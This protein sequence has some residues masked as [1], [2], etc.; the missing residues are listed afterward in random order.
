M[1]RSA[2]LPSPS[3][4][5][6]S[7]TIKMPQSTVQ[8]DRILRFAPTVQIYEVFSLKNNPD[9]W[10]KAKDYRDILEESIIPVVVHLRAMEEENDTP[11]DTDLSEE[12]YCTRGLEAM[13]IAGATRRRERVQA[14]TD[15]VLDG[16]IEQWEPGV[17]D[18]E[19]LANA[20]RTSS[21]PSVK[22]A[23]MTALQDQAAVNGTT[24]TTTTLLN[25]ST[26]SSILCETLS[27]TTAIA[28]ATSSQT[29][30]CDV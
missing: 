15:A 23:H 18:P 30:C 3:A 17:A 20:S 5:A 16:Q 8:K 7:S 21:S 2:L 13:T 27:K 10:F 29:L 25:H 1:C 28:A 26:C 11:T 12:E 6:L 14:I 4:S 22:D 24:S 19:R 9:V